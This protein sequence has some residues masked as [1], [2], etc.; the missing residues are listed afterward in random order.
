ME[1]M[2]AILTRR[3]IRRYTSET[4]SE[5][6][7]KAL[8]TAAMSAPAAHNER[9]WSFVVIQDRAVLDQVPAFHPYAAMLSQAPLAIAV[10]GDSQAQPGYWILD[11]AAATE[12]L[13][14][15]AHAL[16]LGAVWLGIYP[17]EERIQGLR[18]LLGLPDRIIP[19]SL[20]ALGYPAEIKPAV[21]RF[22]PQRVHY[23]HW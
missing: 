11:C 15:A 10:C 7:I 8:L 6:M 2:Q 12:N 1:A 17:R 19:L 16:G 5:G 21:D 9:P 20:I 3:S 22:D 18:Q 23:N 4:I 14:I 13:L